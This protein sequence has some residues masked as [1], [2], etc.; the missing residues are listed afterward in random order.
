[1]TSKNKIWLAVAAGA[2]IAGLAGFFMATDK[3]KKITKKW[4]VKAKE[5]MNEME[6]LASEKMGALSDLKFKTSK[7]EPAA[8]E[9]KETVNGL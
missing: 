5:K 8:H 7:P 6:S 9:I 2:V 3:G 1:M 4:R